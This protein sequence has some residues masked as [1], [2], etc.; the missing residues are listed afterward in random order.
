MLL[1][2]NRTTSPSVHFRVHGQ[3]AL[4]DLSVLDSEPR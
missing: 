2:A 1:Y 4:K 3:M